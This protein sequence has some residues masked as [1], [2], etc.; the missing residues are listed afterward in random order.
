[1]QPELDPEPATLDAP[2][3]QGWHVAMEVCPV[4][5]EYVDWGH[6]WH[7]VPLLAPVTLEYVPMGQATHTPMLVANGVSE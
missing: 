1:M 4:P 2:V 7:M 6:F 3:P 5:P